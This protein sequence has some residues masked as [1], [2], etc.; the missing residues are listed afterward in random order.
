M[1]KSLVILFLLTTSFV[2][3]HANTSPTI[4]DIDALSKKA[5]KENKHLLLFFHKFGCG[6]CEKMMDVTLDDDFIEDFVD[7]HFIFVDIGIDDEGIV[8]HKDFKG[9]K[10]AYAKSLEISFYPTVGFVDGNNSIVYG[11]IGYRSVEKFMRALKYIKSNAY[12]S[13]DLEAFETQL[14]FESD[15]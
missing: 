4:I 11:V 12:K 1:F 9:S 2:G 10:H 3:L 14:D 7:K 6:F 8:I 15:E 13:M 5:A